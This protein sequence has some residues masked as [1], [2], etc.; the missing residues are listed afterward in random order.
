MVT[1]RPYLDRT[2]VALAHRGGSLYA[3]NVGLENTMT[4]FG[5]AVA[6]ATRTSR[7]TST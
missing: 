1:T 7:P 2:P 4:A 5:N 6:S 3:P